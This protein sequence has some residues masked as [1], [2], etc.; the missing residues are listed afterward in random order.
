MAPD[1]AGGDTDF[2]SQVL[3]LRVDVQS[4]STGNREQLNRQKIASIRDQL[5]KVIARIALHA[6]V[7]SW[8]TSKTGK[9]VS[10]FTDD[11]VY[12]WMK[13]DAQYCGT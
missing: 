4:V 11:L 2:T 7:L 5:M 6:Y 1:V 13:N 12:Q 8:K 10:E 3:L 9:P